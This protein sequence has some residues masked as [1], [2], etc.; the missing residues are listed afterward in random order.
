MN[1]TEDFVTMGRNLNRNISGATPDHQKLDALLGRWHTRGRVLTPSLE[2]HIEI[3]GTDT[4]EWLPGGRFLLHWVDVS[5]GDD[6]VDNLEVIGY[7]EENNRY[8]TRFFDH[9]GNS[10]IYMATE[11]DGNWRFATEGARATLMVDPSG[12]R[13]EAK[14]E[15]VDESGSWQPWME[16]DFTRADYK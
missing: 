13:M 5:I 12:D 14:W 15:R 2:V 7:D 4:Y 1:A 16:I 6:K 3:V 8:P 11:S 10:G 9:Q